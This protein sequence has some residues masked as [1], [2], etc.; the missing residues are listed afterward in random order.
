MRE[1]TRTTPN[2]S[3]MKGGDYYLRPL[4]EAPSQRLRTGGSELETPNW[5][6]RVGG[7]ELE[8]P[9]WRL[10]LVVP[11][12]HKGGVGVVRVMFTINYIHTERIG[13]N[14]GSYTNHP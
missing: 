9:S 8:I 1:V 5:R 12:F 3:F 6:F 7:P 2:P 13:V 4:L 11:S 14:E 10:Q